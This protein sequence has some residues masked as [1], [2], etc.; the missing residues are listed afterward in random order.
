MLDRILL[1]ARSR[2]DDVVGCANL[3]RQAAARVD[4]ARSFVDALRGPELSVIAEVKRKSPSRGVL[5]GGL[6]AMEQALIYEQAGATAISVLTEPEHFDGSL[7]DLAAVR[8]A[9]DLPVLRKDFLVESAQVW[10]ARAHGADA[11]LLIVAILEQQELERMLE[12]ASDAGVA[13][14]VEVHNAEEAERALA[15]EATLIG[16][17]NRDLATF[18]VDLAVAERL[19]PAI[20]GS[21]ITAVAESGIHAG[22]DAR[23]M[24]AAGYDA[25][26]VGE[27][28]VTAPDP[29]AALR[30][31]VDAR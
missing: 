13:T 25:I 17:N 28:L 6:D 16:V 5:A 29:A 23:R 31:L 27:A 7:E 8:R 1:D 21:G 19:A 15:V 22:A 24:A 30:R 3:F 4:P 11:V 9:V 12:A 10:E 18:E 26:L 14:L 2:G 20:T